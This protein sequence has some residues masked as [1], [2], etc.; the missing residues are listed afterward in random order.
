V[1]KSA[2]GIIVALPLLWLLNLLG[3]RFYP[4]GI[5][6]AQAPA[7]QSGLAWNV[8][9]LAVLMLFGIFSSFV[10]EKARSREAAEQT[11]WKNFFDIFSDF[12]FIAAIFISPVVFNSVYSLVHQNP[13]GLGDYLLAYQNGFFWQSVLAGVAAAQQAK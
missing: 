6:F 10:F 11:V 13:Q 1:I 9:I 7:E 12:S 2:I 8:V 5:L 3:S 4:G